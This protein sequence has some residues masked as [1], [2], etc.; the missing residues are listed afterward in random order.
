MRQLLGFG[1]K[2][3]WPDENGIVGYSD[4]GC[5][6][7]IRGLSNLYCPQEDST[8]HIPDVADV[9]LDM[10]KI[11]AEQ[12][13]E[14]RHL[15]EEKAGCDIDEVIKELELADESEDLSRLIVSFEPLAFVRRAIIA[16]V[17]CNPNPLSNAV[18]SVGSS[19]ANS[20]SF[21]RTVKAYPPAIFSS[22]ASR[23]ISSPIR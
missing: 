15:Q 17:L 22:S 1:F 20:P 23:P 19:A 11:T 5:A 9:L 14:V 4:N 12:L 2:E 16:P 8:A 21:S 18:S 3:D 7:E 10:G 13:S 6:E